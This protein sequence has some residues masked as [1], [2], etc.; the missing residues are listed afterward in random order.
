MLRLIPYEVRKV[1]QR[2]L[3]WGLILAL[4]FCHLALLWQSSTEE[5]EWGY[6][7]RTVA[8]VYADHSK[9][10]PEEFL[11]WIDRWLEVE[12]QQSID[13]SF[14]Y[15]ESPLAEVG[16][17]YT[18]SVWQQT[19]LLTELRTQVERV[20]GY[21]DYLDGIEEQAE[22]MSASSLFARPGTFA[23]RNILATPAAYAGLEGLEVP[24]ADSSGVK[25]ATDAPITTV[26]L[27]FALVLVVLQLAIP[28]RE[29]GLFELIRPTARGGGATAGAKL[30][31]MAILLLLLLGLF[32]G[33]GLALGQALFGLG[34]LGR[35]IQSLEGYLA[36]PYRITVG[37]Y[38]L[39]SFATQYL[40]LLGEGVLFLALCVVCRQLVTACLVESCLILGEMALYQTIDLHTLWAPL[41]QINLFALLDTAAYFRNYQNMNCAGWPVSTLLVGVGTAAVVLLGGVALCL[42]LWHRDRPAAKRVLPRPLRRRATQGHR[43]A[44]SAKFPRH[45]V[46]VSLL[47]HESRKLWVHNRGLLLLVVLLAVQWYSYRDIHVSTDVTAYYYQRYSAQ[48]AGPATSEHDAFVTEERAMYD[49]L[50]LRSGELSQQVSAGQINYD[51]A[52]FELG[53]ISE[54]M[55]GESGF[56]RAEE[57]YWRIAAFQSPRVRYLDTTG[58][59]AL[60]DDQQAD[61]MDTGKLMLVL[62]LGLSAFFSMEYTCSTRPLLQA[63]RKGWR[64]VSGCKLAAAGIFTAIAWASAVLPRIMAVFAHYTLP[65][66]G[67]S[68]VS[69]A[70]FDAAPMGASIAIWL[71]VVL[72]VR[73][74]AALCAAGVVLLLSA[75]TR[76]GVITLLLSLLLLL[77][78]VA[79]TLLGNTGEWGLLP[80]LTGHFFLTN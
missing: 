12:S 17:L 30:A 42:E 21:A 40:A 48:L 76:N 80:W 39:L 67:A 57:Q 5:G 70:Q 1:F 10:T 56:M 24:C 69:L 63:T 49:E 27:F 9:E 15:E 25:M 78:P 23:Y 66:T 8:Q 59:D 7:P 26:C 28:E 41:G 29:E 32:F 18:Q 46:S 51:D 50:R 43:E 19:V 35:P 20:A 31:A 74:L 62:I 60:L 11:S 3:I 33:T 54:Q 14:R 58:Y 55:K 64:A 61:V 34:D 73:L 13:N 71:A 37:Q 72:L 75:K 16:P 22:Q 77:L 65:D 45:A 79:A 6:S 4:L 36:S 2:P 52:A 44:R 38:L 53:Q 47:G 68:A